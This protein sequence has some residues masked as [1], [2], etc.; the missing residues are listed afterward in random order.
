M[1]LISLLYWADSLTRSDALTALVVNEVFFRL[2]YLPTIPAGKTVREVFAVLQI[3]Q[4]ILGG[5]S[6]RQG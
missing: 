5:G 2:L 6:L 3:T 1:F 4:D